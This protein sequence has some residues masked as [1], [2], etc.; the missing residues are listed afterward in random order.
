MNYGYENLTDCSFLLVV[1]QIL[2]CYNFFKK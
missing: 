1:T 2:Q